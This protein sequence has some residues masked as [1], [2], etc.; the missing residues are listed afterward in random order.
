MMLCCYDAM[1]PPVL[2]PHFSSIWG[3]PHPALRTDTGAIG[4]E[5]KWKKVGGKFGNVR[6]FS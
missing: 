5:K 4:D 1:K 6:N 3:F 2:N